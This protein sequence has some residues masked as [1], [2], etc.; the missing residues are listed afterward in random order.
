MEIILESMMLAERGEFLHESS[1]NKGN[2]VSDSATTP[3]RRHGGN[4][5]TCAGGG[6]RTAGHSSSCDAMPTIRLT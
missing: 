2:S 4:G 1:G 5:R 3:L 6:E